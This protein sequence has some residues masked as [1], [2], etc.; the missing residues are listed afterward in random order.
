MI[1]SADTE[2]EFIEAVVQ[3]NI[4]VHGD[5]DTPEFRKL[6]S[7]DIKEGGAIRDIDGIATCET[8][9]ALG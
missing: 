5:M 6:I 4:R 8:W 1:S 2:D 9:R 7:D 3:H